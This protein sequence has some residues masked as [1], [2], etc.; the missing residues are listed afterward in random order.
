LDDKAPD[1]FRTIS[2]VADELDLPQH[3]LRFWESRFREI[4]P[5]KRGGG[6]RYYRPDDID[7]L[8]GIRHLLYGEGY[9][10]RGVQRILREQGIKFVQV[11]WHEGAAQPPHGATD[12]ED[13]REDDADTEIDEIEE[14]EGRGLRGRLTSLI[15]RDLG[16]RREPHDRRDPPMHGAPVPRVEPVDRAIHDGGAEA[17][18][19]EDEPAFPPPH[20]AAPAPSPAVSSSLA[21]ED[22]RKLHAALHELG[23]C[24][25][26]IDAALTRES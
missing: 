19:L 18:A 11:V 1:A 8:R 2:E 5:M 25:K 20:E 14:E 23:E 24:R 17:E 3:V 10:I 26:L 22:L 7:L 9:T 6:R 12:S 21:R 15:G 4:K 16:E 13:L